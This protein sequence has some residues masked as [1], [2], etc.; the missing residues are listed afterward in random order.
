MMSEIFELNSID[1][2]TVPTKVTACL[3]LSLHLP[4]ILL[5]NTKTSIYLFNLTDNVTTCA[6]GCDNNSLELNDIHNAQIDNDGS[7]IVSDSNR[8][9]AYP[10]YQQCSDGR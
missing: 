7:L 6:I 3:A 5:M 2:T 10:M 1:G 8:V 9:F 4:D